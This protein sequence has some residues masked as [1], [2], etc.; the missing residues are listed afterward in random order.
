[1]IIILLLSYTYL[2]GGF[3]DLQREQVGSRREDSL[4]H[5][6]NRRGG[7]LYPV[8]DAENARADG[9]RLI[10]GQRMVRRLLHL[11]NR[12]DQHGPTDSRRAAVPKLALRQ[13]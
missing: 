4:G 13:S 2:E 12:G 9:G 3:Y 7:L 11:Q 6:P 8:A 5:C 1:M 10:V